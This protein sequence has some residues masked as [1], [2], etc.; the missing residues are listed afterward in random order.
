MKIEVNDQTAAPSMQYPVLMKSRIDAVIVLFSDEKCGTVIDI[1]Y[2][3]GYSVGLYME[4]WA[5]ATDFYT[6]QHFTGSI[7]LSN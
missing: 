6:W 2:K 3:S 5:R 1:G 4:T 7:T